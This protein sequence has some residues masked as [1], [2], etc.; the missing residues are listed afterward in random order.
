MGSMRGSSVVHEDP[1]EM[2]KCILALNKEFLKKIDVRAPVILFLAKSNTFLIE[3]HLFLH[4]AYR[5]A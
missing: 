2:A 3:F 4:H 1:L 5:T